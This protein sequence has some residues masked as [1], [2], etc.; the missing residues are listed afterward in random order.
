MFTYMWLVLF[1]EA[2]VFLIMDFHQLT[3]EQVGMVIFQPHASAN[4]SFCLYLSVLLSLSPFGFLALCLSF[5]LAFALSVCLSLAL[6]QNSTCIL[7]L[8]WIQKRWN[9]TFEC[10]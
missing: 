4:T 1:P 9:S 8:A 2:V 7:V 3:Y 10:S 6:R 5:S